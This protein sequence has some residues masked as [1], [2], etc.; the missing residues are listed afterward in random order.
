MEKDNI[1]SNKR[2]KSNKRKYKESKN[3]GIKGY[4]LA[5]AITIAG[6]IFPFLISFCSN[7]ID[8][9][10]AEVKQKREE[11]IYAEVK[12]IPYEFYDNV[13]FEHDYDKYYESIAPERRDESHYKYVFE[14]M[15]KNYENLDYSDITYEVTD[16]RIDNDKKI[17][18][19]I[20]YQLNIS[21][22]DPDIDFPGVMSI[23]LVKENKKWYVLD[24]ARVAFYENSNG[25]IHVYD[26]IL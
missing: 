1:K 6:T 22:L 9:Y 16:Y 4:L 13:F 3:I 11:K 12:D 20:E 5:I 24:F 26:T 18:L 17:K 10:K 21:N 15:M 7:K 19:Y 23:T 25:Y 2:E 14:Y 8:E